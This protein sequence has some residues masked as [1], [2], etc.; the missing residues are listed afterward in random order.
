MSPKLSVKPLLP[1]LL[2][3]LIPAH[4]GV[5]RPHLTSIY[6]KD[7]QALIKSMS[8][9]EVIEQLA[10][11]ANERSDGDRDLNAKKG[12]EIGIQHD[13]IVLSEQTNEI[14]E[15]ERD[16]ATAA[17]NHEFNVARNQCGLN[18]LFP[19]AELQKVALGHAKYITYVFSHSQ[20]TAF[21]AHYQNEIPDIAA[22][23][24]KNNPYYSG[25]DVKN[26]LLNA[27][28]TNIHY[29]FTENVAQ[30]MYFHSAGELTSVETAAVSM[31]K[32]LLA[33][34]YH[35]SSIM[36]PSSKVVG[37]AV[38]A[39]KPFDRDV[40]T[41]QGYALVSNAAAT[42]D[43]ANASYDGIL[44]YPCQGVTGTATALYNE[45]PDPVK[46]MGRNLSTDPI[47]QPVYITIPKA[48]HIKIINIRFFDVKR[49]IQVP[50]QLL[51]YQS[52]PYLNTEYEL[53]NNAAFILPITDALDSCHKLMSK[54]K[55]CGLYGNSDYQVSFDIIIND[56]RMLHQSFNF[57]TG[58]ADYS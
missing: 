4:D 27:N 35:L 55:N 46:H 11:R 18:A 16:K 50:T 56:Q 54:A 13:D 36:L 6:A 5:Q 51:D 7:L 45:T 24:S 15:S 30:T 42:A 2:L 41:N 8:L 25:L 3:L 9:K 32:S 14:E 26:R 52:D 22:V 29:G 53:P 47:G 20:P 38:V 17:V 58:A 40:R 23:T 1:L 43:T 49:N 39:Y 21:N 44:T 48:K 57:M 34:P 28:Y 12:V 33:A 10:R 19:D 31:A 37:T